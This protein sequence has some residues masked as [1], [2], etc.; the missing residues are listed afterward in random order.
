MKP[1]T[2]PPEQRRTA[3]LDAAAEL[4]LAKGISGFT[5]EDVTNAAQV[6][7]GTFYLYFRSKE[8]L[9]RALRERFI[10]DLV[11]RQRAALRRLPA[12]DWPGRLRRWMELSLRG[13]LAHAEL[14]D[15]LFQHDGD[16]AESATGHP[17]DPAHN[18]HAAELAEIIQAGSESGAFA[19]TD[20][21][22]AVVLLY[23]TMHGT[24]D[25]LVERSRGGALSKAETNRVIAELLKLCERYTETS[26]EAPLRSEGA[27]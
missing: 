25:Y 5:V 17:A 21:S 13:Y 22:L 15:A 3:L 14:H 16:A 27:R 18:G 2:A 12:D 8:Q 7:K 11:A 4:V 6:A 19:L 23:N 26:R 24:A 9:V 20:P 1:R 10:N